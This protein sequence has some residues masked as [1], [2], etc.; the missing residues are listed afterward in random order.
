ML[1]PSA[2]GRGT[3][4][5]YPLLSVPIVLGAGLSTS[6]RENLQSLCI[7]HRPEGNSVLVTPGTTTVAAA[8]TEF[9]PQETNLVEAF[10]AASRA[11]VGVAMRSLEA[12]GE[13]VSLAQFRL[14]VTLRSRGPQRV[15]ELA[16]LLGVNSST[17][18]RH[19]DR[20]TLRRLLRRTSSAQDGRAVTV[21]LTRRGETLVHRVLEAR[22]AEIRATLASMPIAD[23][24]GL[25]Y[26]LAGFAAALGEG[27]DPQTAA[28]W[29]LEPGADQRPGP[30]P[31]NRPATAE[32]GR[33]DT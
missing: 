13:E 29:G 5:G 8:G 17:A 19:A 10:V 26:A 4:M 32:H 11:L 6:P 3:R 12:A 28:E 25:V 2:S 27:P 15:S 16:A 30:A 23:P 9:D 33:S 14:L 31:R 7:E 22:R 1:D 20:L 24:Q 21:S 18:T